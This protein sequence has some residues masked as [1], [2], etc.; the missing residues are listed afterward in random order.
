MLG[1]SLPVL[2]H[3]YNHLLH[4]YSAVIPVGPSRVLHLVLAIDEGKKRPEGR[5]AMLGCHQSMDFAMFTQ[6]AQGDT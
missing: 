5:A 6:D 1:K 4:D 3:L 2:A